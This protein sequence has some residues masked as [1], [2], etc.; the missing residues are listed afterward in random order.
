MVMSMAIVPRDMAIRESFGHVEI[1]KFYDEN[2]HEVF[3]QCLFWDR[4]IEAWRLV[5]HPSQKPE[6]DLSSGVYTMTWVDGEKLREVTTR[7]MVESWTQY[8]RE[9]VERERFPKE[10]RRELRQKQ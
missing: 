7:S 4:E 10:F 1:N 2:G 8:D 9:I 6:Y 5:K 3:T